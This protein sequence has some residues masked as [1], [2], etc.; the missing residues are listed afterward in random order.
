MSFCLIPTI[1]GI[2]VSGIITA[3]FMPNYLFMQEGGETVIDGPLEQNPQPSYLVD[4]FSAGIIPNSIAVFF[5]GWTLILFVK[6]T[7]IL[8]G[9]SLKDAIITVAVAMGIFFFLHVVFGVVLGVFVALS[10]FFF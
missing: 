3:A 1:I 7:R 6:A 4:F 2:I 5:G 8:N 9:F 10:R